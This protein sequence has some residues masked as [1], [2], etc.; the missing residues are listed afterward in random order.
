MKARR[1]P[2]GRAVG[3]IADSLIG[4][5]RRRRQAREPRVVL[6]DAAGHARVLAPGAEGHDELLDTAEELIRLAGGE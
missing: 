2:V 1:G 6:Y 5:V 3:G 4:T